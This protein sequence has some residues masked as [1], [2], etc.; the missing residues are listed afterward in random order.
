MFWYGSRLLEDAKLYFKTL[1]CAIAVVSEYEAL[2]PDACI[3]APSWCTVGEHNQD[4]SRWP[5]KWIYVL[6]A[7]IDGSDNVQ[8]W[9]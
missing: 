7:S 2:D 1:T 9:N 3:S 4:S 6:G 8:V 5:V